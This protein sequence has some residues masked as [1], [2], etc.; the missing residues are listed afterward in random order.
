MPCF[1]HVLEDV[2]LEVGADGEVGICL[3]DVW[4][5]VKFRVCFCE[6]GDRFEA[7]RAHTTT[8]TDFPYAKQKIPF[9]VYIKTPEYAE[10]SEAAMQLSRTHRHSHCTTGRRS[11]SCLC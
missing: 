6:S 4:S 11:S 1:D 2:G 8:R 7:D 3:V 10:L 9:R 5:G